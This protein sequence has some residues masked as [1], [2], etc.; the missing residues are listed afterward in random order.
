[1]GDPKTT[2]AERNALM[3]RLGEVQRKMIEDMTK[4]LQTDPASLNKKQDDF[5]CGSLQLYPSKGG[6]VEGRFS[7]GKNFNGGEL[8]VTGTMTQLR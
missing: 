8:K 3:A 1:M 2:E 5:G 7:C 6:V 4:G